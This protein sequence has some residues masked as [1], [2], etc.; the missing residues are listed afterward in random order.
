MREK[1]GLEFSWWKKTDGKFIPILRPKKGTELS[2]VS[3]LEHLHLFELTSLK[4]DLQRCIFYKKNID[5]R[6]DSGSVEH[7]DIAYQY[8]NINIDGYILH[9]GNMIYLIEE[10]IAFI[11]TEK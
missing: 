7:M 1:Y 2:G 8:P 3:F 11:N 5:E 6:F 10:W 9:M 4:D